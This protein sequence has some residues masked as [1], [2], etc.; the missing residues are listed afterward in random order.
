MTK[1]VA[2]LSLDLDNKWAYLRAAGRSDWDQRPGY[3]DLVIPRIVEMLGELDLPLTTFVVGRDLERDDN[4]PA[5]SRFQALSQC[6]FANHSY[7]HL[8]WLHTMSDEEIRDEIDRTSEH[9][10]TQLGQSPKGFRGPG[11]SCPEEV[12][13]VLAARNFAYDASVFP[14][15][16]APV[17]RT[18]FL[19]KSGLDGEQRAK[20]S[21]LYGGWN[22]VLQPN[23]PFLR[24]IDGRS[25][26]EM[27]VTVMPFSRTPI[28]F[29]YFT[30][31]GTFSTLA[32]KA[33]FRKAIWLCRL[34]RTSAS[35]LLHPPDFMG[36]EDDSDMAYFPAMKMPRAKK[37]ELVRWAL[38]LYASSFRV[39][40][41]L[42]HVHELNANAA[43]AI[44]GST[45]LNHT[46]KQTFT[47]EKSNVSHLSDVPS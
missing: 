24:S 40:T 43:P 2:N 9:I 14:T 28:H 17:A 37:L 18:V 29:S 44:N 5:I 11:F 47:T 34:T 42:Q 33:Y 23:R 32:A 25:L 35:L 19:L 4:A 15:S 6:E 8:P 1:Q 30:F 36:Q 7:N 41:M 12:L 46:P 22:S 20:A 3:F 39:K 16:I 31:L 26:W 13:R 10:A 21:K 27:P 45:H 38:K